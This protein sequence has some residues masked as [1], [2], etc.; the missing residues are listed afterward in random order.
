[1]LAGIVSEGLITAT[2]GALVGIGVGALIGVIFYNT[3]LPGA[4]L[5]FDGSSLAITVGLV[6]L[7]VLAV[8][9]P[10]ALRAARLPVVEALRVED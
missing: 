6:Y 7:S 9:I 3:L 2:C 10:S 4:R 1:M 8:T 5:V